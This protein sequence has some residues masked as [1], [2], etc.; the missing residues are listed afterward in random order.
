MHLA[1]DPAH[2]LALSSAGYLPVTARR[3][4]QK[5]L[6]VLLSGRMWVGDVDGSRR[7]ITGPTWVTWYPGEAMKY[8]AHGTTVHWVVASPV[9][10]VPPGLPRPGSLVRLRGNEGRGVV[11]ALLVLY[12][13]ESTDGS[14]LW[15]AVVEVP[16]EGHGHYALGDVLEV[17]EESDEDLHLWSFRPDLGN[18]VRL[19]GA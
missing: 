18:P 9:G 3:L 19:S 4:A 12:L 16:G 17:V 15:S 14:G 8:G 6:L 2:E 1:E 5:V 13:D 10:P 7:D 11:D